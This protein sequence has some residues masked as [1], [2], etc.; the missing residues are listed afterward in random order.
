MIPQ[1][2]KSYRLHIKARNRVRIPTRF[3]PLRLP[4]EASRPVDDPAVNGS[5]VR[6]RLPQPLSISITAA[7]FPKRPTIALSR[8]RSCKASSWSFCRSSRQPSPSTA[9]LG[10]RPVPVR[11][12]LVDRHRKKERWRFSPSPL[13]GSRPCGDDP[14]RVKKR[15]LRSDQQLDQG[16]RGAQTIMLLLFS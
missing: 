4:L 15:G 6:G 9:V 16:T 3:Q 13:L 11:R 8:S 10:A 12:A 5:P 2:S 7:C 1:S 14:W